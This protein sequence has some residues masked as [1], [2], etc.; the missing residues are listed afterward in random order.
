MCKLFYEIWCISYHARNVKYDVLSFADLTL[1]LHVLI[2]TNNK[3]NCVHR[4]LNDPF[5]V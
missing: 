4:F 3:A 5:N 2:N 1:G